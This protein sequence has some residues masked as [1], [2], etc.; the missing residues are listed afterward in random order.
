MN[1]LKKIIKEIDGSHW[2]NI[3]RI[4]DLT[5]KKFYCIEFLKFNFT[6]KIGCLDMIYMHF[7]IPTS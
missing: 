3:I 5:M 4:C 7:I 2:N 1:E 6:Y